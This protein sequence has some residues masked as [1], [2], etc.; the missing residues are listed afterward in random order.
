MTMI[1]TYGDERWKNMRELFVKMAS[2]YGG[3]D[4]VKAYTWSDIDEEFKIKNAHILQNP[5]GGGYWLWKPY[6]VNDALS[7]LEEGDYLLYVD[8]GR[9]I[10][11]KVR[12][13]IEA[14]EQSGQDVMTFC[15]RSV[16]SLEKF[17]SKRDAF[18]LLDCEEKEYWD[19]RQ[20]GGGLL[21][22]RKTIESVKLVKDW[23]YF[24]QDERITT[25]KENQL[26]K[27]NYEG[28]R[29]NRHDQVSLS[30]LSKKAGLAPFL[31][32][33]REDMEQQDG[34]AINEI[35]EELQ[36]MIE[37]STYPPILL[38]VHNPYV[39]Y[40]WQARSRL[41]FKLQNQ[42]QVIK[43]NIRTAMGK[44]KWMNRWKEAYLDKRARGKLAKR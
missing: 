11:N 41:Y 21:V 19:T 8:A 12:Y 5:R 26:G 29:E 37:R 20:R 7:K 3:A 40:E 22:L 13:L 24:A 32:P 2:K 14:L 38:Y 36:G 28:F 10:I 43:W 6:I 39:K 25:D 44:N 23:L 31:M 30:L 17:W 16:A 18:I 42:M 35:D 4:V 34:L 1:V 27:S 33:H 15:T 9:P